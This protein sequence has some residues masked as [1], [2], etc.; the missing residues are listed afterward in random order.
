MPTAWFITN[1]V[2]RP[3]PRII[4]YCR[5]NDYT[6]AIFGDGGDWYDTE[7][8]GGYAIVKVRAAQA[9]LDA[10]AAD[11]AIYRSPTRDLSDLLSTLTPGQASDLRDRVLA[12][13]YTADEITAVL[14]ANIR[15]R[16]LGQVLRFCA[17]RRREA[18][19]DAIA[20]AI[21]LDGAITS[22]FSVDEVNARVN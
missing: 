8:L 3:G 15:Q 6:P 7:V 11:P 9:T 22:C 2:R 12:M 10:I 18:R 4:R 1:Y 20:D 21:V 14:G 17:T 5:M 19:Y 13:G 16:T